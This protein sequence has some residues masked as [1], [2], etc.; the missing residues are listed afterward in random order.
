MPFAIVLALY[1]FSLAFR[2][3]GFHKEKGEEKKRNRSKTKTKSTKKEGLL[4]IN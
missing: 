1:L 3:S 2:L 4:S